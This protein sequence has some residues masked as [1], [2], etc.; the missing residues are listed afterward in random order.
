VGA[1]QQDLITMSADV[2][3]PASSQWACGPGQLGGWDVSLIG[4]A[5]RRRDA[6]PL[7]VGAVVSR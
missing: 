7:C 5:T 3:R 1:H 6:T 2:G 4:G